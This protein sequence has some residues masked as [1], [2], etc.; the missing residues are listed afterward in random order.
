MH[1][2]ENVEKV[3]L[4]TQRKALCLTQ[5]DIRA[6]IDVY[7][8]SQISRHET[9]KREPDLRTA[10]GYRIIYNRKCVELLPH[11]FVEI[12][13]G[14]RDRAGKRLDELSK[15]EGIIHQGPRLEA[16]RAIRDRISGGLI[17]D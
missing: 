11:L 9:G 14:I 17:V 6:L 1:H 16:L 8:V 15:G 13:E 7:S 12:G 4:R 10:I 2:V 5:D 3:T